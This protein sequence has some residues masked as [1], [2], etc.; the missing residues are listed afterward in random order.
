MSLRNKRKIVKTLL[1]ADCL[2]SIGNIQTA[3]G[4]KG[5][6]NPT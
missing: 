1:D 5:I 2:Y 6:A 4:M 3:E